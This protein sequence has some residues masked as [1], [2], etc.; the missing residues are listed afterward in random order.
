MNYENL[1]WLYKPE[2]IKTLLIGEAPPLSGKKY[3]YDIPKEYKPRN[4]T[5]ENDTSLPATIFNHYFG[6]MPKN[7]K[8]YQIYL[9]LLK[10]RGV[11]LIDIINKNLEIRKKDRTLNKENIKLLVSEDNLKELKQRI[12]NISNENT[13]IIFLFRLYKGE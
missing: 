7:E 8:E 13:K 10:N 12:R 9:N 1:A 3:F 5:I 2:I 4:C 6:T 11:F